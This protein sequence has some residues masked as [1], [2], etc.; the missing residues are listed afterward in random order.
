MSPVIVNPT[1]FMT[2]RGLRALIVFCASFAS[3]ACV[4]EQTDQMP[5]PQLDRASDLN[6]ELGYD[7]FRKGKL[8]EAKEKID[9]AVDQNPRSAKAQSAA[10]LLYERLGEFKKAEAHFEKAVSLEPKNPDIQNTFAAFLCARNRYAAGEKH[11]L[12]AATTPL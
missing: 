1:P 9:R 4:T 10:G 12:Q 5:K 2:T 11:A 8:A 7:Y 3:T 6:L